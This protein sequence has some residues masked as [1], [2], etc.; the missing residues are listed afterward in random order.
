MCMFHT[1]DNG[2]NNQTKE[3]QKT[4]DVIQTSSPQNAWTKFSSNK[5]SNAEVLPEGGKGD[6][7]TGL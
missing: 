1:E 6:T 7:V 4:T 5:N 3:E 2:H